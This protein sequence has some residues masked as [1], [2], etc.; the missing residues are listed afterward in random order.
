MIGLPVNITLETHT[1]VTRDT[2]DLP[3]EQQER[4]SVLKAKEVVLWEGGER[5]SQEELDDDVPF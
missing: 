5:I 1:Y 3:T 4:R 2:K